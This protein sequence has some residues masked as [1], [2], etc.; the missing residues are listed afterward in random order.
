M[1]YKKKGSP[2]QYSMQEWKWSSSESA[3]PYVTLSNLVTWVF[4]SVGLFTIQSNISMHQCEC[5]VIEMSD[6]IFSRIGQR[7]HTLHTRYNAQ[8]YSAD[9]VI[10]LI[11][12]WIPFL[13]RVFPRI[14][15]KILGSF[16]H[17]SSGGRLIC[18]SEN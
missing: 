18:S 1:R 10:A 2:K 17:R 12:R 8:H 3:V 6:V 13:S 4:K 15:R 14:S 7:A 9:S 5:T 11:G 16:R